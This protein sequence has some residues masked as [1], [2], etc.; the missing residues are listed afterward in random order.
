MSA[1]AKAPPVKTQGIK[2]KLIPFILESM[3]W[4]GDG[5]WIE[6]FLGSGVVL[7]NIAPVRAIVGDTNEHII[8]L[9]RGIQDGEISPHS[10]RMHL[11][12]EG[13][14]LLDRGESHYYYIR[15][16]FNEDHSSL[17]FLFLNRSCFNGLMR[18]NGKGRFNS[19][20]C[21][22]P[23]RFRPAY[24]T[25]IANQVEWAAAAMH[26]KDWRFLC[27]DWTNVIGQT[28]RGDFVYADPPYA[29]RFADYFN[30]WREKESSALETA[31]KR[32]PCQFLYSM[33]AE[34]KYRRND[35][36][37]ESFVQY[38]IRTRAHFYHLGASEN[39]RNTMIEA[40]V[41]G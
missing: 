36:L 13:A 8:A 19:P 12:S 3:S 16:R 10:V 17:D 23:Q 6:P 18:F 32:L 21:R 27:T 38:E 39:L 26:G 31:L 28:K 22:K 7:F 37:Y 33:W 35:D 41:L 5:R 2:T 14:R 20:F 40:L 29:G 15:K 11:E 1:A 30:K 9:Y 25:K 24:I 34:N 4:S